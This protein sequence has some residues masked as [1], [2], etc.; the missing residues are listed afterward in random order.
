MPQAFPINLYLTV[1]K[2]RVL[3]DKWN[4]AIRFLLSFPSWAIANFA[5]L[6]KSFINY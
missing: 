1:Y 4:N 6:F 5:S 2:L 3:T